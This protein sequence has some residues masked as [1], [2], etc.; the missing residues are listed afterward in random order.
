[1]VNC[2]L[3]LNWNASAR[4]SSETLSQ[5]A[6]VLKDGEIVLDISRP[7]NAFLPTSP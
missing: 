3:L 5:M 2:G 7:K 4:A 6:K 1:M